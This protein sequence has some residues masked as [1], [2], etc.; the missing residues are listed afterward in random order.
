MKPNDALWRS[1]LLTAQRRQLIMKALVED[2]AVQ[3]VA[4][5]ER[6]GVSEVTIRRDLAALDGQGGLRRIRGGALLTPPNLHEPTLQEREVVNHEAKQRIGQAAAELVDDGD[7]IIIAGGTTTA[8]LARRLAHHTD[9]LIITPTINVPAILAGAMGVTVL[10]TGGILVGPE[11]TLAGHISEQ[12]LRTLHAEKL[13]I[14]V[15][16]L[17]I[18]HGLT[19]AHPSEIGVDMAMLRAAEQ[20]IVL[21]DHTK[22]G[23]AATCA[24]GAVTDIH[25]LITDDEASPRLLDELRELGIEVIVA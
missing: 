12:A 19:S 9:L 21:A 4:L 1:A 23:R 17:D 25:T 22:L 2:E 18:E 5:A 15:N 6:F 11:H 8:E 10:I 7:T 20:R 24:F 13:F 14:S 3:V 16:A